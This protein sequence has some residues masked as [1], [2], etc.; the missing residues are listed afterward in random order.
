MSRSAACLDNFCAS[1]LSCKNSSNEPIHTHTLNR[2]RKTQ[3][4]FTAKTNSQ[5]RLL[6]VLCSF[7]HF[8]IPVVLLFVLYSSKL[9][10]TGITSMMCTMSSDI[11]QY[12]SSQQQRHWPASAGLTVTNG[13]QTGDATYTCAWVEQLPW[14][15]GSGSCNHRNTCTFTLDTASQHACLQH[16]SEQ[17]PCLPFN[18]RNTCTFTLDTA[19]RHACLQHSS[20]SKQH[21]CHNIID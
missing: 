9:P 4:G 10:V 21:S 15:L 13:K 17:H 5:E 19:S 16:S 14:R 18:H 6:Y 1:L 8:V 11:F 20:K 7:T 3:Y 2:G 12:K